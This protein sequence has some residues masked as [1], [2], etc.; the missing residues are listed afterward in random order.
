MI[1]IYRYSS[2]IISL[3][4]GMVLLL[5]A[6]IWNISG[7]QDFDSGFYE[8]GLDGAVRASVVM[9]DTLYISGDFTWYNGQV[10][11]NSVARFDDQT[12]NWVPLGTGL[13]GTV[14]DLIVFDEQIYAAG[15]FT[16]TDGSPLK[17]IARWN[18]ITGIWEDVAS[19]FNREVFKLAVHAGEL[20]AAGD[21]TR[22]GANNSVQRIARLDAAT[23]SWQ[24]VGNLLSLPIKLYTP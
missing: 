13:D 20:Y 19:G 8:G 23:A 3:A 16:S 24:Q 15:L 9:N 7:A 1:K 4:T 10:K 2:N 17:N 6:G 21:F 5:L 12:S 22:D 11:L 14:N 18:A